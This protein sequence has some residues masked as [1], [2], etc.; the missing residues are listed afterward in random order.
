MKIIFEKNHYFVFVAYV[1]NPIFEA[2][3]L[4]GYQLMMIN[5]IHPTVQ[6]VAVHMYRLT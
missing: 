1:K 4:I 3:I 5:K 6:A 2:I